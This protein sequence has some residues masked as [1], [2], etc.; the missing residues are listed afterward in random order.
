M[1]DPV[2]KIVYFDKNVDLSKYPKSGKYALSEKTL[3]D[4]SE[5]DKCYALTKDEYKNIGS[6]IDKEQYYSIG[7]TQAE[8]WSYPPAFFTNNNT[9][10]DISLIMSMKNET[11]ERIAMEINK[12]RRKYEW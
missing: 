8:I 6:I 9:V 5:K 2:E 7:G 4:F 3:I 12:L 1:I 10:D 11:D